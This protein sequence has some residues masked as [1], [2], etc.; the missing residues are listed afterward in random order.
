MLVAYFT[1]SGNTRVVANII[2]EMLNADL[3]EIVSINPYPKDYNTVTKQARQERDCNYRPILAKKIIDIS[4]YDVFFIG[5]PNWWGTMPMAVYTFLEEY[6]LRGKTIIPFCTH[7][8]SRLGS[9]V[10]DIK[11]ICSHATVQEGYAVRG[12]SV[13]NSREEITAWLQN[14]GITGK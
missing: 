6:D 13:E 9:S 8:G 12:S 3:F 10:Q 11:R 1:H 14:I 7:E 4:S 2:H 5:Y